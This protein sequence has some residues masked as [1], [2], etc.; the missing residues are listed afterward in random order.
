MRLSLAPHPATGW[1]AKALCVR[2]NTMLWLVSI[3]FELMELTFRVS[4]WTPFIKR[5]RQHHCIT[6]CAFFINVC[7]CAMFAASQHS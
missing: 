6:V 5:R 2:N 1:W 7:N 4:P 3:S